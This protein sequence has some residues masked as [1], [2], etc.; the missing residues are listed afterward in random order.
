MSDVNA[1]PASKIN[2]TATAAA[3]QAATSATVVK[4]SREATK[5]AG[6]VHVGGAAMHF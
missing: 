5:D 3:T 6:R 4:I 1:L 2:T